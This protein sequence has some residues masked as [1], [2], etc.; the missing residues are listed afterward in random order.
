MLMST[1]AAVTDQS[2]TTA[3][4]QDQRSFCIESAQF[5]VR[6]TEAAAVVHLRVHRGAGDLPE[7][8]SSGHRRVCTPDCWIALSSITKTGLAVSHRRVECVAGHHHFLHLVC[9]FGGIGR[10]SSGGSGAKKQRLTY[11]TSN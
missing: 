8:D 11:R 2:D 3:V 7:F 10:I 1:A 6:F 5:D 4:Q 9:G